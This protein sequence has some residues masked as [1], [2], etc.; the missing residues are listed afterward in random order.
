VSQRRSRRQGL[1]GTPGHRSEPCLAPPAKRRGRSTVRRLP[2]CNDGLTERG[3][4]VVQATHRDLKARATASAEVH[5]TSQEGI[6]SVRVT[7]GT[8]ETYEVAPLSHFSF[9]TFQDTQSGFEFSLI[10]GVEIVH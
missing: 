2:S 9:I 7:T 6:T 8:G 1:R 4:Q 10:A 3:R 5:D